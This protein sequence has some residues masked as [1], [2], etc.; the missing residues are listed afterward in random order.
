V[1]DLQRAHVS[2]PTLNTATPEG[3]DNRGT[4]ARAVFTLLRW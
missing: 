4:E 2:K 3:G 1:V